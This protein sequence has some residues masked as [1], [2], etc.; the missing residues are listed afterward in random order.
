MRG[1]WGGGGG[2]R[3]GGGAGVRGPWGGG[4]WCEKAVGGLV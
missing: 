3:A 1:L 4:E 2:E